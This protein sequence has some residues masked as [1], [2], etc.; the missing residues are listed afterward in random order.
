MYVASGADGV[1]TFAR[2]D[3]TGALAVVGKATTAPGARNAVIDAQ[4]TAYVP[5]SARGRMIVVRPPALP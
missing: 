2:L 5:D 3:A 1:L 4:G